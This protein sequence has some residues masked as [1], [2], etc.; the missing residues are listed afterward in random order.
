MNKINKFEKE[1]VYQTC[2]SDESKSASN[3]CKN[4][5]E[6]ENFSNDTKNESSKRFLYY[7]PV[8]LF[9]KVHFIL[10]TQPHSLKGKI[11]FLRNFEKLLLS[12]IGE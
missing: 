8:T 3:V 11:K 1:D 6:E 7:L 10:K 5:Q 12:E 4:P 2:S 9:K